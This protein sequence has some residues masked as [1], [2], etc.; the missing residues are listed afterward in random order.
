MMK[1]RPIEQAVILAAGRGTRL[2]PITDE[3]PKALVPFLG[4]PLLSYAAAH[5]VAAGVRR[6]AV[7]THHLGPMVAAFVNDVLRERYPAIEWKVS[8]E[9]ELLGTGGALSHLRPW[10]GHDDFFVVNA[11][12]V[13]AADLRDLVRRREETGASAV[14]MVTRE[15]RY[16]GL[17]VVQTDDAGGLSGLFPEASPEGATF[18]GVHLA[19]AGLLQ[20]LPDGASCVVRDGYLPWMREGACVTT[21]ETTRFWADTGTPDRYIDAHQRGMDC[22][23]VWRRLGILATPEGPRLRW[24]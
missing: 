24:A 11:D 18:C 16:A 21:Y 8:E 3:T 7:N 10:L 4:H 22:L 15:P 23:D 6:I 1:S 9:A 2:A 12:A 14:W 19:S 17:R 5:L 20:T 13:F